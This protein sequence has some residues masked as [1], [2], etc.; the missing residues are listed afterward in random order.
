MK[1]QRLKTGSPGPFGAKN[2]YALKSSEKRTHEPCHWSRT[3]CTCFS[4]IKRRH[5][6]V[7]LL[8]LT[9]NCFWFWGQSEM[10]HSSTLCPLY[11]CRCTGRLPSPP[12]PTSRHTSNTRICLLRGGRTIFLRRCIDWA[13]S[14][15]DA[16]DDCRLWPCCKWVSVCRIYVS[17]RR[18]V[19]SRQIRVL[20]IW[21]W[22]GVWR[23][24]GVFPCVGIRLRGIG[25]NYGG[26]ERLKKRKKI[27]WKSS[28]VDNL[29]VPGLYP[30]TNRSNTLWTNDRD[31]GV[32]FLLDFRVYLFLAPNGPGMPV[33]GRWLKWNTSSIQ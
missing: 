8:C 6:R 11:E 3:Y 22:C 31:R 30:A 1:G 13:Y 23:V 18:C 15:S 21:T 27:C 33:F 9:F 14:I 28:R 20:L 7:C 32:H 2:R 19:G 26:P 16:A 17:R 12:Q 10:L 29:R 24:E 5:I 4:R 25:W